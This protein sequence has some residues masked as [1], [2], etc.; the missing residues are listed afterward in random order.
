MKGLHNEPTRNRSG[1]CGHLVDFP[2]RNVYKETQ[3]DHKETETDYKDPQNNNRD[4][5]K[6]TET[7]RTHKGT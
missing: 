6:P 3:N 5:K 2:I 4:A 1:D 7:Q